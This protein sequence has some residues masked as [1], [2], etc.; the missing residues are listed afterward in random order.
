MRPDLSLVAPH[1]HPYINCVPEDNLFDA[2]EKQS[3][4]FIRFLETIPIEKRDYRYAPGKW[5]IKEVLQHVVDAERIFGYRAL[6]FAR[7]DTTPPSRI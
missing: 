7:K 4:S 6:R 1:F 3:A 5:T 2:F